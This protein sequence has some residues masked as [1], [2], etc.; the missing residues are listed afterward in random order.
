MRM[1]P[2]ASYGLIPRSGSLIPTAAGEVRH[3]THDPQPEEYHREDLEEV[4]HRGR[5]ANPATPGGRVARCPG[6]GPNS[7][8]GWRRPRLTPGPGDRRA[9]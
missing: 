2:A 4:T 5:P 1:R 6:G 3:L 7:V 9:P 8:R